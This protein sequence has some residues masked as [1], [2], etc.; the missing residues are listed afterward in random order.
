MCQCHTQEYVSFDVFKGELK[1]DLFGCVPSHRFAQVH[2][3]NDIYIFS[4]QLCQDPQSSRL[5][6]NLKALRTI[7]Q[8][9]SKVLDLVWLE[10]YLVVLGFVLVDFASCARV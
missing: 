2:F 8:K 3:L 4:T 1:R 10:P 9:Q 7:V 5:K 6:C